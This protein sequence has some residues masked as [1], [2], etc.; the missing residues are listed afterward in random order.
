M[1][2]TKRRRAAP[3]SPSFD[4][5]GK[6]SGILAPR[7][8]TVGPEHF[9]IVAVD[10]AKVSSKWMFA[11][12]Y[13]KVLIAPTVV[14]HRRDA[15]DHAIAQIRQAMAS[16]QIKDL[17]VVLEQTGRYHKPAQRAFTAAGLDVRVMYPMISR[18]FRHAAHP[19]EKT[20]DTDLEGIV[21][22][23]RNGYGLVDPPWEPR[24]VPDNNLV[25]LP[26]L[27]VR[28]PASVRSLEVG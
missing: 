2:A 21:Q 8:R 17:V 25:F 19:G 16:H 10:C 13:G 1:S 12:F 26:I 5:L 20:D 15:F 7:V 11:D 24:K 4:H 28:D 27:V 3:S 14:D 18:H 6:P 23:T 9:G 22:V